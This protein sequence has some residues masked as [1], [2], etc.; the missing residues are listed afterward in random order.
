MVSKSITCLMRGT[1]AVFAIVI[2]S[3][4]GHMIS[5]S[6][7]NMLP[8]QGGNAAEVNYSMFLGVWT[9]LLMAYFI[10]LALRPRKDEMF[11]I[12]TTA[13]DSLTSLFYMCGGIALAAAMNIH[14]CQNEDYTTENRITNSSPDTKWRCREAQAT[15]AFV[16]FNFLMFILTTVLSLRELWFSKNPK[17][18]VDESVSTT[19]EGGPMVA[20]NMPVQTHNAMPSIFGRGGFSG[21]PAVA[22][23]GREHGGGRDLQ[24]Q[25]SIEED[26]PEVADGYS[27]RS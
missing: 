1:Q 19:L 13:L 18:D 15:T 12:A 17:E 22:E 21:G 4:T 10:P 20:D 14:S 27:V 26:Y 24:R 2:M 11:L 23:M 7:W 6:G 25:V 16:W 5:T 9:V 8:R 3:L